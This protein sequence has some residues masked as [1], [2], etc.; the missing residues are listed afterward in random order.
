MEFL[1][2]VVMIVVIAN[3]VL[4][5][6]I[7]SPYHFIWL[8]LLDLAVGCIVWIMAIKINAVKEKREKEEIL[9]QARDRGMITADNW[10]LFIDF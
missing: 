5:P 7:S 8:L 2:S 6:A 9:A 1:G 3:I 4:L 10:V